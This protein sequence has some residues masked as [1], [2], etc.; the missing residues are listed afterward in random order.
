MYVT[1]F[2][3]EAA[4]PTRTN[5]AVLVL[6]V[7]LAAVFLFHGLDKIVYGSGG[8]AWVNRM[9]A[10]TPSLQESKA[11]RQQHLAEQPPTSISFLGTQLAVAW[12]EFFGGLALAAGMLTRLA[13]LGLIVIQVG[14]VILVTAPR[15]FSFAEGGYEYNLALIAMCLAL[16]I[17]GAGKWSADWMLVPHAKKARQST[18]AAPLP[19]SGPHSVPS[20]ATEPVAPGASS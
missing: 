14:A 9:Y 3:S 2:R 10:D 6:R 4:A 13:A 7:S 12:G 20:E 11:G 18:T 5:L 19:V 17:L 1:L 15:G 16:L 8:A